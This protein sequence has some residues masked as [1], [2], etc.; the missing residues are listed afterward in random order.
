MKD[1]VIN[2]IKAKYVKDLILD[3]TF[4]DGTV[5]RIDFAPPLD[6]IRVPEYQKWKRPGYFKKFYIAGGNLAWG[7]DW[8]IIFPVDQLY[9]NDIK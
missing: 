4:N 1:T 9:N 5:Q 6:R 8:D 7:K 3:I 2:V